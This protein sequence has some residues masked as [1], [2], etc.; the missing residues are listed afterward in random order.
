MKYQIFVRHQASNGFIA[1]VLGIPDCIAE[2]QTE[3]EAVANAK[4]SL[5]SRLAQGKI[6]SV[7]LE[8]PAGKTTGNPWLDSFG[9]FKDDPTFDDF[10]EKIAEYRRQVDEEEAAK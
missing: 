10:L 8:E 4:A 9:V 6:V 3:E 2:G 1:A 5:S 7:E